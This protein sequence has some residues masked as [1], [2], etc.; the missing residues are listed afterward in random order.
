MGVPDTGTRYDFQGTAK[1][2]KLGDVTIQGSLVSLGFVAQG[3]AGG[4]LTFTNAHGSVTVALEGPLQNGFAPLPQTFTYHVVSGTG[5]Y[6]NLKDHGSLELMLKADPVGPAADAIFLTGHG[7]F[8]LT[9]AG[10]PQARANS[11]IEG[12]ALVGPIQPVERLG[13]PDTKPLPGAVI[14]IET[15]DGGKEVARAVADQNGKFDIR[16]APGSYLL[17]A[18]PPTPG[19]VTVH[20]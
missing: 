11:G 1:L 20:P 7:T 15:A 5:A 4:T 12:V 18:L 8:T 16:L 19:A 14:L 17:V 13:V 10:H 3:H 9:V 2:A 6:K